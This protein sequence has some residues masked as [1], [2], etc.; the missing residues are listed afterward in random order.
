M[1]RRYGERVHK[2][3]ID[4][5][6]SCPNRDG[7]KGTDGCTFCNNASFS[8]NGHQPLPIKEQI[9]AGR[10][11]IAKRTG[12]RKFIAYFQA[13]TS[14]HGDVEQ[15]SRLYQEAL[16][17][18]DVIGLSIGTRPDC[19]P[20]PVLDLLACLRDQGH[21]VWLELGLQSSFDDTLK[22]IN[23]CHDFNDYCLALRAAH[24]RELPV[25]TH[26]MIGLPGE[27]R[28]HNHIT[29]GRV[30]DLGVEGLKLH[31]LH[32]VKGTALANQWR[33]GEYQ[34]LTLEEYVSIAAD[35]VERTPP[36]VIFHRLT[37]TAPANLLLAPN[38]CGKKWLVLNRL[39]QELRQRRLMIGHWGLGGRD[40]RSQFTVNLRQ[41]DHAAK[42]HRSK[43]A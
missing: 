1:L 22:H 17:E 8:P 20:A 13:Y 27:T 32:V 23:R 31:P 6:F 11:V 35:L 28:A 25:C 34:P 30:L 19:V 21:E 33:R 16:K 36:K 10:R 29:L 38:W 26:L 24:K 12:A 2:V 37:A 41:I 43:P 14:T 3:A 40:W 42:K 18:P 5:G 4:A 15:L 7:T 9:A 39:E